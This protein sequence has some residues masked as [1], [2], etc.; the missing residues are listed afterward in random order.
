MKIVA[1]HHIPFVRE[2]FGHMGELKLK[3]GRT[4]KR[5]DLIDADILLV[6]SI[7][8]VNQTLLTGTAVKFVGSVTAGADHLDTRWLDQQGIRW[9]VATGFNAPPVAD[10]VVATIAALQTQGHLIH[11][12]TLSKK[13]FKAAVIG[14]GNVGRL[15]VERL[16]QLN[17]NTILCDPIRAKTEQHFSSTA[18]HE[19]ADV[20][21]ITLHVPLTLTGE[22][23]TRHF[24][25]KSFLQRQKPGCILLNASRGAIIDAAS[26]IQH[27]HHL[28]WCFDVWEHEPKIDK[29]LLAQ[30]LIATPHIAGYSVQSKIRGIDMMYRLAGEMQLLPAQ[31]MEPVKIPHQW[32]TFNSTKQNWQTVVLGVFNPLTITDMMRTILLPSQQY[33]ALFDEMRNQFNYRHE[34]AFTNLTHVNVSPPDLILLKNL[35]FTMC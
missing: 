12:T 19:L 24:I 7:T 3:S 22:Y 26:L 32:L 8:R 11:S 18:I 20:D 34:F 23:S 1:D 25:D 14:V 6:R 4:I 21:L 31:T 16:Q 10:Y 15:V 27:G 30:A 5:E 17:F 35:G 9:C 33:D 13:P 28:H 2:Y 29:A